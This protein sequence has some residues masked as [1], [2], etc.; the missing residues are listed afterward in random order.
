MGYYVRI[1]KSTA[2]I[3]Q[4]NLE[5]AYQKMCALDVTHDNQKRGGSWSGGAQTAKWFSWMDENY[6]ETCKNAQDIME[7]LGF[8]C[9]EDKDGNLLIIGYDSKTGQED[10]FLEAITN[11]AIG[12]IRWVGEDGDAYVTNFHGQNVIDAEPQLLRIEST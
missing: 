3:P 5:R 4:A 6:T 9:D 2:M 8:E 1:V 10:L 7:M 12:M 11:D